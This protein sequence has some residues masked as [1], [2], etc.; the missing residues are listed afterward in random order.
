MSWF[1]ELK[2]LGPTLGSQNSAPADLMEAV[3]R[4][5]SRD[6][7]LRCLGCH[8][9]D[10]ISGRELTLST[11]LPG[12]QCGHCHSDLETHLSKEVGAP[13]LPVREA[14]GQS[15]KLEGQSAEQV[16]NFCGN[17]H[18][19]WAEIAAQGNPSIANIR[20]QPY[21]LTE[22]KCYDPDDERISC[23]A[24]HD[25]HKELDSARA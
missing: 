15:F 12:V 11:L 9:T 10:A 18:R 24:C 4:R 21:R 22:S 2:G 16:S 3:G 7:K 25:P 17:C 8:A 23:L 13:L 6:D 5:M 20:F 1:R 19:T 14:P